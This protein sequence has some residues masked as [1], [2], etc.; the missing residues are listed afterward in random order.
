MGSSARDWPLSNYDY[1]HTRATFA[2]TIDSTN[3]ATLEEKWAFAHLAAGLWGAATAAPV[4][5]DQIVYYQDMRSSVFA[6]NLHTGDVIWEARGCFDLVGGP[7]GV[8]VGYGKVFATN[9]P[10]SFRALHIDSG[11]E[12]WRIGESELELRSIES[13]GIPPLVYDHVVYLST[14]P[15]GPRGGYLGGAR[16]V[17][18]ALDE[19]T[20]E[21][22]W[23]FNTVDSEDI[24]GNPKVNS[25]GGAWYPPTIDV[26]RRLTYWGTG[27]PGPWPGTKEYPYGSSRPGPNLYTNS[28]V[29]VGIGD[30][31]LSW[32]HQA[33]PHDLFD[34][35]FQNSPVLIDAGDPY[36]D[37]QLLIGSGKCGSVVAL[38][39]GSPSDP[40]VW[41]TSLGIHLND[42]L[43][44]YPPNG[45]IEVVPNAFGTI[46]TAL[47]YAKGVVYV[48]VNDVAMTFT[49]S[50]FAGATGKI[51]EG[52]KLVALDVANGNVLWTLDLGALTLGAVLV[53]NDLVIMTDVKGR[54][55]AF[56]AGREKPSEEGILVYAGGGGI[57]APLA[58]A[59]DTLI[60]PIGT[61]TPRLVALGLPERRSHARPVP[62][63]GSWASFG[64]P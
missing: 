14:V 13:V 56:P 17:L 47:A 8:A 26:K 54:I 25:G 23:R 28:L 21:V 42:N 30:G 33:T 18:H 19:A 49:G 12:I 51:P 16:G 35:D 10:T 43:E 45:T 37:R 20:G 24:W 32:Y 40:V 57:Y 61:G 50:S 34:R 7:N 1:A 38:D 62:A 60:I 31:E 9:G 2:S 59:D 29:A 5:I 36:V 39:P 46:T 53:V 44:Q 4:A 41:R 6:L 11:E 63:L 3:V 48:P 15:A 58:L 55:R 27:N 22:L 52:G 64:G